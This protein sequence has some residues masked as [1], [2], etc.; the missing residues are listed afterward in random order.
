M[1]KD[2]GRVVN[3]MIQPIPEANGKALNHSKR[4]NPTESSISIS[5]CDLQL[6]GS[7]VTSNKKSAKSIFMKFAGRTDT[8]AMNYIF[9]SSTRKQILFWS[10]VAL[11]GLCALI[12]NFSMLTID[13][14]N[15]EIRNDIKRL[16]IYNMT[17]PAITICNNNPIR[18][19]QVN[20]TSEAMRSIIRNLQLTSSVYNE[21]AWWNQSSG[22]ILSQASEQ[23]CDE[24]CQDGLLLVFYLEMNSLDSQDFTFFASLEYGDCYTFHNES[25]EVRFGGYDKA[26]NIALFLELD[27]YI[28]ELAISPG[29]R[30]TLHDPKALPNIQEKG[31]F[32]NSLTEN[33]IKIQ[34]TKYQYLGEPY[35][36]CV[37]EEDYL[38]KYGFKYTRDLCYELCYTEFLMKNCE[39]L[40]NLNPLILTMVQN[41][42]K[43]KKC[44]HTANLL[45]ICTDM[46]LIPSS[47]QKPWIKTKCSQ[48]LWPKERC[49]QF[50]N[51]T[52]NEISK[53]LIKLQ[54]LYEN[55]YY[56]QIVA[57][58]RMPVPNLI[59]SAHDLSR[60]E[61]A[62]GLT[63]VKGIVLLIISLRNKD[64]SSKCYY[65]MDSLDSLDKD[66]GQVETIMIKTI[67]ECNGKPSSHYEQQCSTVS[68]IFVC[69]K[70]D[71]KLSSSM[72]TTRK[73]KT[74][75]TIFMKFAGRTD[76][77]ALN[78]IFTSTTGRQT[79]FW[80]LIALAGLCGT[81]LNVLML[82]RDYL[83]YETKS[84]IQRLNIYD[85]P[86]PA[87]TI[88]NNNQVRLSKINETSDHM[89]LIIR[90]LKE[91]SLNYQR[92][93]WWEESADTFDSDAITED[94][95]D[96]CQLDG[97]KWD[98]SLHANFLDNNTFKNVGHQFKDIVIVC[99]FN[100]I[101]CSA[102]N[103]KF[104]PSMQYGNCYTFY[105]ADFSGRLGG[106]DKSLNIVIFLELDEYIQ[107]FA[108]IPG[109]RIAIH[110]PKSIPNLEENGF[111]INAATEN[112][113]RIK[114]MQFQ[115]LPKPYSNCLPEDYLLKYNFKYTSDLC[116]ET[117]YTKHLMRQCRCMFNRSPIILD[118][119][120]NPEKLGRCS[121]MES[122]ECILNATSDFTGG[123]CVCEEPCRLD[124]YR[125]TVNSVHRT[126]VHF[127][128]KRTRQ[129]YTRYQT[130][131]L[132][133]EFHFNRYLTRRRR[134]EIAHMLGL[135]ERQIK[136][137]FQNRRMKW[138]KEN[139]LAKLTGP[140]KPIKEECNSP[141]DCSRVKH[142]F[143]GD[144]SSS[145]SQ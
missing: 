39:C 97:L 95:D 102:H 33:S 117:C 82:T 13:Y 8:H 110:D 44:S 57:E 121:Q 43:F 115:H 69:Q 118:M 124:L 4:Q 73:G 126:E 113:I 58:A 37:D 75:G 90:T 136:I 41:P 104:F 123:E 67:P 127:E 61:S 54:L 145:D 52:T 49:M 92:R 72:F 24:K 16:D 51:K 38:L 59:Y 116:Y 32:I 144:C 64:L 62:H 109:V 130:L 31:V 1:D 47:R 23:Y 55:Q 60:V 122:L 83:K 14:L 98:F 46:Q 21:Q 106:Y 93:E 129:T 7:S 94:C 68:G 128:Q 11:A 139:N 22:E 86:L 125:F 70:C 71:M 29:V 10:I 100:L 107:E 80:S 138:K 140:E 3:T 119:I 137:W 30:I 84:N 112:L 135:T 6:P 28:K 88:C 26:L 53:N 131:E 142:E 56:E 66:N 2:R 76:T 114:L 65:K 78:Y 105:D 63:L 36:S 79:F 12:V 35:S 20:K 27:E 77:H 108:S 143:N 141:R 5:M 120:Y 87:V 85:I 91:S 81:L 40:F 17:L 89:K 45:L 19:S 15:Y 50:Y 96:K 74:A 25:F 133:K 134:I 9:T 34:L 103:F 132:E 18:M 101:D 42:N 48:N 99:S 111:V